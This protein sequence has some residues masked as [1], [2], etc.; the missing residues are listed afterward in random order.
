MVTDS[1]LLT[2]SDLRSLQNPRT[3][4][5]VFHIQVS[6]LVV[7]VSEAYL[8]RRLIDVSCF[9]VVYNSNS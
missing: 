7:E 4:C 1:A 3:H 2:E 9:V 6:R 5:S 8:H